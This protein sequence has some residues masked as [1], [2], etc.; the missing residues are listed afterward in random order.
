M[1]EELL[2]YLAAVVIKAGGEIRL[3]QQELTDGFDLT[4][5]VPDDMTGLIIKAERT[6]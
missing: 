5:K 2:R 4:L 1:N 6:E 3:S